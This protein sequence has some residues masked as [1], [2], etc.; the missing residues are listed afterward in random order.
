ML[1]K[2]FLV[3]YRNN[4]VLNI[5]L[6]SLSA[7]DIRKYDHEVTIVNNDRSHEVA[8]DADLRGINIDFWSNCTRPPFSTG[9]LARNWNESIINGVVD[10]HAPQCDY[11]MCC[12]NDVQFKS[13]AFGSLMA[14]MK[15]HDF[16]SYGAGDACH[17]HTAASLRKVGLFDERFCNIGHQETDYFLRQFLYNR[18]GC[19]INDY[20][21]GHTWN[22][23]NDNILI[24]TATGWARREPT[25]I[26]SMRYHSIA[27]ATFTIKWGKGY[28]EMIMNPAILPS[29]QPVSPQFFNYPYFE[30]KIPSP[31]TRGYI[32]YA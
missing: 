24:D 12:Q 3:T 32:K 29:R 21:H 17:L 2:I 31:E 23:L 25:H 13:N 16:I 28:H 10:L 6:K 22:V 15:G 26:E 4:H 7:S 14:H 19:S 5:A 20:H 18:L 11:L 30:D 27:I 1:I 8:V 9:H